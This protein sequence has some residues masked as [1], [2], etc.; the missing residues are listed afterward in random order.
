M[1]GDSP[2]PSLLQSVPFK[3]LHA[4]LLPPLALTIVF[5]ILSGVYS[6]PTEDRYGVLLLAQTVFTAAI[7]AIRH[8]CPS[9][10]PRLMSVV[11][12]CLAISLFSR[13]VFFALTRSKIIQEIAVLSRWD[14]TAAAVAFWACAI[15]AWA[16]AVTKTAVSPFPPLVNTTPMRYRCCLRCVSLVLSRRLCWVSAFICVAFCEYPFFTLLPR[17][18][19]A[20][21]AL[22]LEDPALVL[23]S[24]RM[25][26][27]TSLL[28]VPPEK[29]T[30]VT[31][32]PRYFVDPPTYERVPVDSLTDSGHLYAPTWDSGSPSTSNETCGGGSAPPP[33]SGGPWWITDGKT[34]A[35]SLMYY[36]KNKTILTLAFG[37]VEYVE[38]ALYS[39][40]ATSIDWKPGTEV[41]TDIFRGHT[42][43]EGIVSVHRGF[44][45]SYLALR[46]AV[47][48][49][50][51]NELQQQPATLRRFVIS[52]HSMG[53]AMASLAT[54]DLLSGSSELASL[55]HLQDP[56]AVLLF[57][58][59]HTGDASFV[60]AFNAV[61]KHCVLAFVPTDG[62]GHILDPQVRQ[63]QSV[64]SRVTLTVPVLVDGSR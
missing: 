53:A 56:P 22:W 27:L 51:L 43:G 38:N 34:M 39:I 25:Q 12:G 63:H 31:S 6:I 50:L 60:T 5:G 14:N 61:V 36:S 59:P 47:R 11:L 33:A 15:A 48:D 52:G 35:R 28:E 32:P 26:F 30:C 16:A 1:T 45:L 20:T 23:S 57:A 2:N 10:S 3:L 54:L 41:D 42:G 44:L 49:V 29:L 58:P 24:V 37:G 46:G 17:L 9:V 4:A 64:L 21:P 40:D 13:L 18:C 55:V 8:Y 62:V 19:T 7:A